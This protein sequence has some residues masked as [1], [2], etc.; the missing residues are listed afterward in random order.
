MA[1]VRLTRFWELMADEF[2][3]VRAASLA[4][5]HAF[6]D[7]GDRTVDQALEAGVDPKEVWRAV[8]EAFDVPRERR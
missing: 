7:L 3:P 4:A 5:D 8:C 2:G 1:G 6:A